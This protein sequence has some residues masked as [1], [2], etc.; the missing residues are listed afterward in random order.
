VAPKVRHKRSHPQLPVATPEVDLEK[1]IRREK[2]P[3]EGS[4]ADKPG[5]SGNF[6]HPP[7]ETP[8]ASS[9]THIICYVGVSK[10]LNFGSFPI[11]FSSPG[12]GLEGKSLN[13][14]ISPKVVP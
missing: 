4:S 2:A 12:L 13:I 5:D 8:L 3:Q 14:P 9:H 6:H 1:I 11:V 7:S 10:N